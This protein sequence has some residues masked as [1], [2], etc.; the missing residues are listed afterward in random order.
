MYKVP[1]NIKNMDLLAA[2]TIAASTVE[3]N[4]E[5]NESI[6]LV[7]FEIKSGD[8]PSEVAKLLQDNGLIQDPP[9]LILLLEEKNL[10][11][12]IKPGV[13][14]VPLDI[15]NADLIESITN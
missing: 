4:G 7:T 13:Y 1:E 11:D 15:K 8:A 10:I 5:T 9:S 6:K 14:N 12:D 2:I 3:N